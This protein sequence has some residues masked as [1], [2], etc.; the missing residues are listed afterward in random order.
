MY[1]MMVLCLD[2]L[3]CEHV[4]TQ[5]TNTQF[6]MGPFLLNSAQKKHVCTAIF[7]GLAVLELRC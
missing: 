7:D 6:F 3:V 5:L 2:C 1:L 4:E